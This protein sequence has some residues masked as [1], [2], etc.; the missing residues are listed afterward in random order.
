MGYMEHYRIKTMDGH[1]VGIADFLR[2]LDELDI[3]FYFTNDTDSLQAIVEKKPDIVEGIEM[4]SNDYFSWGNYE[5]NMKE[6]SRAFPDTVF[7]VY[8]DGMDS[9]DL[10]LDY[11]MNGKVQHTDAVIIYEDFNAMKLE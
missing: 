3:A 8:G 1:K 10:W 4:D 7:M 5:E 11:Y 6:L 9:T 2:K